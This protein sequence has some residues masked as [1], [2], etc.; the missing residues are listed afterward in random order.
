M[1]VLLCVTLYIS[2]QFVTMGKFSSAAVFHTRI[3]L[4]MILS[5]N[6]TSR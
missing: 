3:P 1:I 2:G 5:Q 4:L 6:M